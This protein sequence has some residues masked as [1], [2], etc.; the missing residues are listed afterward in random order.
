MVR[1]LAGPVG[2][3]RTDRATKGMWAL[4]FPL[5][6]LT[7]DLNRQNTILFVGKSASYCLGSVV[8]GSIV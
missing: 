6:D 1:A 7:G 4:G 3:L 8:R 2:K 5:G